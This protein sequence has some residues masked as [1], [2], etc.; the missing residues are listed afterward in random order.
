M[1]DYF[2]VGQGHGNGKYDFTV[3]GPN[4]FL[5]RL[6]G[7]AK[8][9]GKNLEVVSNYAVAPNT[10][11]LAVWF[12]MQNGSG[13][14]VTFTI[15]SNKYRPDGPW[16]YAVGAGQTSNDYFNAVTLCNG[17]YDFT[18]TADID[19]GWSRR[20]V[21]HLETGQASVSG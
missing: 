9:S 17:W 10:G 16:S 4:R 11:E 2:N 8:G 7:D 1:R 14:A 12:A 15:R 20:F 18:V 21:G 5:R 13:G 19:R 6:I 3:V